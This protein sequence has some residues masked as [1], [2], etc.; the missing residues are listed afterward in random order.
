[1]V[2]PGTDRRARTRARPGRERSEAMSMDGRL[3]V[4][5]MVLPSRVGS[6]LSKLGRPRVPLIVATTGAA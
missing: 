2:D 4:L 3:A 6:D 1:M 5:S